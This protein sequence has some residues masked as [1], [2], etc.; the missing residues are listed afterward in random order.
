LEEYAIPVP[1]LIVQEKIVRVLRRAEQLREVRE[2]ANQ[3]TNKIIQSVF[4]KMF[5]NPTTNPKNWKTGKL[6]KLATRIT[7]GE[8]PKWQGFEYV[9]EGPLFIRSENVQWG[10]L[11]LSEQ[12]RI[13][14]KFYEKLSRSQL[15][16]KDVLINLVG[17]SIGRAAM[18]PQTI[19]DANVNQAVGVL[20]LGTAIRPEFL[21][22]FL[23]CP[24]VQ[25]LIQQEK[26][27][28][29]RA[30]IS[31]TDLREMEVVVP[32]LELQ[33]NFANAVGKLSSLM[34][35]QQKSTQ[36]INQLFHSLMQKAFGGQLVA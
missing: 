32:P 15:R 10:Y 36:E 7:K 19:G 21:V 18:V 5:G 1:P 25:K 26:V 30:N 28:A 9:P 8:S 33:D 34:Q 22:Q 12:T 20:S 6:G 24:S 17:A 2:R 11:D 16:P 14:M 13:P 3:L 27:D 31:L 35:K 29:A 23:I 4:L